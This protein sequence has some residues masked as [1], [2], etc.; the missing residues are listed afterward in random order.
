[1]DAY[2]ITFTDRSG[3]KRTVQY[4]DEIAFNILEHDDDWMNDE[5]K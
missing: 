1:M 2:D 4:S 3:K 5:T